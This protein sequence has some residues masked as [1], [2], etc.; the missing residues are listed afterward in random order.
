MTFFVTK[1]LQTS[2]HKF[3]EAYRAEAA[4]P[5]GTRAVGDG[6]GMALNGPMFGIQSCGKQKL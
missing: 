4:V 5:G 6:S 1:S 2:G 3:V